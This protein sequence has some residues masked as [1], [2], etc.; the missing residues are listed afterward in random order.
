MLSDDELNAFQRKCFGSPLLGQALEDVKSI[1]K[2]TIRDGI[3]DNGLTLPGFLFLHTLFIQRG[4]HETTWTV[5]RK[6]GYNDEVILDVNYL[7]PPLELPAATSVELTLKGY[8]FLNALFTKYDSDEDGALCPSELDSL[9]AM[10]AT[11]PAWFK[12]S[13]IHK[14]VETDTCG[15]ITMAGFL[16]MWTL[17]THVE[18]FTSLEQLAYLGYNV[19]NLED[20]QLSA[21]QGEPSICSIVPIIV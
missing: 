10:S 3:F 6:F 11:F 2:R 1:V 14:T 12:E 19:H 16:S 20:N 18:P 5:L 15:F 21:I 8:R 13:F 7:R 4:R 9:F 17:M